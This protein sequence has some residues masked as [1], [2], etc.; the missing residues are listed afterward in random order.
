MRRVGH[1]SFHFA[2]SFCFI[3]PPLLRVRNMDYHEKASSS[4]SSN[5]SNI[6]ND[7]QQ[8]I[9]RLNTSRPP[10]AH[11]HSFPSAIP[12]LKMT[13]DDLLKEKDI[14]LAPS[15]PRHPMD[16]RPSEA[17][18]YPG[19]EA[20]GRST[21]TLLDAAL[22]R[23]EVHERHVRFQDHVVESAALVQRMLTNHEVTDP[24]LRQLRSN[25]VM[26]ETELG[27]DPEP[28]TADST[29]LPAG[30]S[31][32]S[33][34]MKLEAQRRRKELERD[35]REKLKKTK[36]VWFL[37]E[38]DRERERERVCVCVCDTRTLPLPPPKIRKGLIAR[39]GTVPSRNKRHHRKK[40]LRFMR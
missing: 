5:K 27:E 40:Q 28:S 4:N 12:Q 16:T 8:D 37:I 23:E 7:D 39:T 2:L 29:A 15:S 32:L 19:N 25:S 9:Q 31:V 21:D 36:K 3:H 34:L 26:D 13:E 1:R 17:K 20:L 33:S 10:L 14:S 35:Q 6:D 22:D 30:G 11:H 24:R 18:K 38:K